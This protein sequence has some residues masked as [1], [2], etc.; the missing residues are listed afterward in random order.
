MLLHKH[1][2]DAAGLCGSA[3]E[4][5]LHSEQHAAGTCAYLSLNDPLVV[6]DSFSPHPCPSLQMSDTLLLGHQHLQSARQT[7]WP[8]M[9][10]PVQLWWQLATGGLGVCG[11]TLY[12]FMHLLP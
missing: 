9:L 12:K 11:R 3:V 5:P 10:L 4:E 7:V 8:W 1:G 6:L 2:R